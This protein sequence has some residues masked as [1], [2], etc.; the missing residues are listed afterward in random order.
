[1]SGEA[2]IGKSRL[3]AEAKA[4]AAA[5]DFL[6]LQGNC[7]QMDSSYPYAP[8]LD[9]LRAFVSR[10]PLATSEGSLVLEFARLLPEM[11]QDL[12]GPIPIS[13]SDPE[14]EK[15]R[16]FAAL[17]RF[18][19]EQASQRPVLLVI[20]DLHWCDDISLEFL[21]T[22]AR[23]CATHPL[24]LLMTY[25]SDEIQPVLQRFLAQLDRARLSQELQLKPF[26][27]GDVDAMLGSML[28]LDEAEQAHLLELIYPLTEGNP[29]FV[30]EVLTSLV[31]HREVLSDD[32]NWQRKPH[33]DH[34]SESLPVPRSVQD[35][36]QQRT[37]QLS[38]D[39]MQVV[40][41]AAVA[42]RRFDFTVLQQV[43]RC[44]EEQ[45]LHAD[46]GIGGRPT[47]G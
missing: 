12:T 2:G 24:L 25:R 16:L 42:G 14:Q 35:A 29:F 40:T 38:A 39:A 36:V 28:P 3:L 43:M 34:K 6:L 21:Q 9:L 18:F 15:R 19:K 32:G 10:Y 46:E 11:A 1:M 26:S 17:T 31:S 7:F 44:D 47:R 30:E 4:R 45:L 8:L 41:F 5:Q 20:E 22:L 13:L 33:P 23:L 27:L 37:Q